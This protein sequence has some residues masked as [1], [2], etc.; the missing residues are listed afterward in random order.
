[1]LEMLVQNCYFACVKLFL[2]SNFIII[3]INVII[4]SMFKKKKKS[5][6]ILFLEVTLWDTIFSLGC[7]MQIKSVVY[8]HSG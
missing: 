3:L 7:F 5:H 4:N 8:I 2:K 6:L 1:M